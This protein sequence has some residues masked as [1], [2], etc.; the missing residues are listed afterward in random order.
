MSC[1]LGC[2]LATAVSCGGE[3]TEEPRVWPEVA[4]EPTTVVL[5]RLTK[6]QYTNSVHDLVGGTIAVPISLEPDDGADGFLVVGGSKSSISTLGVERYESAAYAIAEQAMAHLSVRDALVPCEPTVADDAACMQ[7]FVEAFGLRVFRRPLNEDELTRYVGVG[8]EAANKLG[9]FYAGAEFSLAGLLQ[10][11]HFLFR[12]ELGEPDGGRLRYTDYEMASRLAFFLWNTTPDDLL[13]DA[14]SAGTL[15]NDADLAKQITRMLADTRARQGV[16][17]FFTERFELYLLDDLVKDGDIFT[18]MSAELG[19]DAREQTLLTIEDLVFDRDGDYRTLFTSRRTFVNRKLAS[20][21]AVPAPSLDGFG[22]ITLPESGPRAGLLGHASLLSLHAHSTST[23][24][25]LRGKFIRTALLCSEIP[26]PPADVDTSLP[27][28]TK[29]FPTLRDRIAQHNSDPACAVCHSFLDPVG[30]GLER[31]DGIGEF[32]VTENDAPID[33]SGEVDG[34]SFA[35][36]EGLGQVIAAHPNV[37]A[38]V[39]RHLYR[40]AIGTLE[41]EGDETQIDQL[42]EQLVYDGYS[43]K[44]LLRRI[45]MS[46]GFRFATEAEAE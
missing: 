40:Y 31:F 41:G 14:A 35:D 25:T 43:L 28:A 22:A 27:Q 21:Y 15:S 39:T 24:A 8:I 44:R 33:P 34:S 38:C 20:L 1:A 37:A 32:R 36:A 18:S 11:P 17:N 42:T 3:E 10:S 16:R 9:D 5:K 12:V 6:A 2:A 19:P 46:D 45:A 30:L 23:S 29:T 13:L 4:V 7:Q 26:P